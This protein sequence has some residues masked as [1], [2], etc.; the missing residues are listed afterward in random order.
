MRISVVIPTRDR[1]AL[2]SR[3][4]RSVE[5]QNHPAEIIIVD[6]LSEP[7]IA[8]DQFHGRCKIRVIRNEK[9]LTAAINRNIGIKAAASDIV[10]FLDDDDEYLPRKFND[11]LNYLGKDTSLDF[12]YAGTQMKGPGGELMG[13]ANGPCEIKSYL[14]WRF[15]HCN[16]MA[17]RKRVF[18]TQ[19]FNENMS[20]FEDVEFAGRL[21]RGF[22]GTQIDEEHAIWYRDGRSDQLTNRN[23]ARSKTNWEILCE[24]FQTEI[25]ADP[26]LRRLYYHKMALLCLMR[27]DISGAIKYTAARIP[28]ISP[29]R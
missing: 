23:F 1:H 4:I 27:G 14:F 6:N 5:C 28:M 21:I 3:A 19:M 7:P 25:S 16:S 8:A 17:I 24:T 15:M 20:T 13:I 26:D 18:E 29:F 9:P 2:L 12:V 22:K 10:C 11:I